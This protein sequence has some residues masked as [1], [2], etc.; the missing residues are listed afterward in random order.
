MRSVTLFRPVGEK[1]M[2]LISESG[3]R[4][5]P[6]RLLGQP[7]FYPVL[8]EEYAKEISQQWN[9]NDAFSNHIGFVTKFEI[10]QEEFSKYEVQNVGGE[11]HNELWV[12]AEN[13][14]EF[15]MNIIGTIEV[16]QIHRGHN[17]QGPS[18]ATI[19]QILN[20]FCTI[21]CIKG[22]I[23]E[24]SVDIMVNAANSSLLGGGGVDG[25]IHKAGGSTILEECKLIRNRQGGCKTGQSVITTAG[26]LPARF[27]IH[28]VGPIWNG[29]DKGSEKLLGDCYTNSLSLSLDHNCT[30]ISFPN[31]S[32]GVYRF[33][34]AIAAQVA[35]EA[36][37]RF[38]STK[39]TSIR[40]VKFICFDEENYNLYDNILKSNR[41]L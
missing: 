39:N 16:V 38:I 11:H 25:A 27:V 7:L 28:T 9:T 18:D 36:V 3:F 31:I 2:K 26:D 30:S 10:T 33:P 17:Y 8:N 6:P 19:A 37:S 4:Q 32:T 40:N 23:T 12:P 5:F 1:E 14:D 13:L 15:N 20:S 22:D 21:E 35:I 29:E 41:S 24:I 34:K